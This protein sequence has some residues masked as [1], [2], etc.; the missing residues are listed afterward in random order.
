MSNSIL[1]FAKF[2]FRLSLLLH[3]WKLGPGSKFRTAAQSLVNDEVEALNIIA[4]K[5]GRKS[6]PSGRFNDTLCN[7]DIF[8]Y[9]AAGVVCD[10]TYNLNKTCHIKKLLWSEESL[11]GTIPE[12]VANLTHLEVL[13]F[14]GN[15]LH[16]TIPDILG[17]MS[18]LY[19]LVLSNNQF[20][21]RIPESL[22][23]LKAQAQNLSDD[24][25]SRIK[26]TCPQFNLDLSWNQLVGP[27]PESLGNITIDLTKIG[28]RS[29]GPRSELECDMSMFSIDLRYNYL[30]NSIP[31]SLGE[32]SFLLELDASNNQLSGSLQPTLG[33]LSYL[34][35]LWLSS[36]NFTGIFP[37]SYAKFKKMGQ[38]SISGNYLS[39]P[40]PNFITNW[41]IKLLSGDRLPLDTVSLCGN[42]FRGNISPNII[43][44]AQRLI[45]CD[46]GNSSLKFPK[47][48]VDNFSS[49]V[50]TIVLRNCSISGSIPAYLGYLSTLRYLDLSF[51]RLTGEIPA[52]FEHANLTY[53]SFGEN[54]LTGSIPNWI[55]HAA[56]STKIDLSYNNFSNLSFKD[57]NSSNISLFSCCCCEP[58][59]TTNVNQ[60]MT[61]NCPGG[62][63]KY[64]SL[65]INCGGE[66]ATING[67][68]YESD[69]R[70]SNFYV[71]PKGNWAYT[72]PESFVAG[73]TNYSDHIKRVKCGFSVSEAPLYE[74]ARFSPLSLK[75]Y[76]F[77]L[78]NGKYNVTLHF[79]EIVYTEDA[80]GYDSKKKR[81]FDVYIQGNRVL[82][83][84][85]I[86]N[87]SGPNN[88]A[89]VDNLTAVVSNNQ[90]EIHFYWAG[91][92]SSDYT[93]EPFILDDFVPPPDFNGPLISA[94][95]VTPDFKLGK[96]LSPV[97]IAL[98]TVA[99]VIFALLLLL[100]LAWM[101]G[102]LDKED[103]QE[104]RVGEDK[105]VT[106]KQ[107]RDATRKFSK[108]T[109][110]GRGGFGTVYKAEFPDHHVVAVKKLDALSVEG[111]DKLKSEIYTL[112]SLRHENL[113][114][115]F[116]IYV[117][118][119]LYLLIYEYMENRS[120]ADAL[121]NPEHKVT[122]DWDARFNICLGIAKGLQ[123]LHEHPRFKM[124]HRGIK[125]ANILLDGTLKSKISD[126][127]LASAYAEDETD[128]IKVIKTEAPH[129][130]MAPEYPMYGTISSKY[131][132]YGFGVVILELVSGRKNAGHKRNQDELE[133][134]VDEVCVADTKGRLLG[135]VDKSLTVY[136][137]K[138]VITILK[139]AVKCTNISPGVRPTMSEVVS[140]LTEEK[141]L[142]E[143]S[144][145]EA[146]DEAAKT[147]Q[148][149]AKE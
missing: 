137:T 147:D 56:L 127:G 32:I 31:P 97:H 58:E 40:F 96:K 50:N 131:D 27:I 101:M 119:G 108:D 14:S 109:E 33:N 83:D 55:P 88:V 128:A 80:G 47:L 125:A 104:I 138:Q 6:P 120:L 84:F 8:S 71:S 13:D 106:L 91:K 16:G 26:G 149:L 116:D 112:Q 85:N 141:T 86:K 94:I 148:D 30:T 65:Y 81:V 93:Q 76:G 74:K 100:A 10:C 98:I 70:T 37:E 42:N 53:M 64:S 44:V 90:L 41:P 39:G 89:I 17:N 20:S 142:D 9:Y 5:L 140:V 73:D 130:Y 121:F 62:K 102:W 22:G 107:L 132:V 115:L 49:L 110:I 12:E 36:N 34:E 23:N 114:R 139:L 51:N 45:I 77:C 117:G 1:L 122:L 111:I 25:Y 4:E 143:I 126:F 133:F 21:G 105:T 3:L 43:V 15:Q 118:K 18:W 72:T 124:V 99:S 68:N 135:L 46:V 28:G 59:K 82:T 134:L 24:P 61:E 113:V 2:F 103:L 63:P 79:A 95:S 11:I 129:G 38:F 136:E 57:P 48:S 54:M 145:P 69:N 35:L 123:Y 78:H 144:L 19:G 29:M 66:E 87:A 7:D 92:G 75:Y 146:S 52:S 60:L 67:I